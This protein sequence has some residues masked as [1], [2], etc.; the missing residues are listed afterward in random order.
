VF[1]FSGHL[2]SVTRAAANKLLI[3]KRARPYNILTGY[4]FFPVRRKLALARRLKGRALNFS[5]WLVWVNRVG[6]T[7]QSGFHNTR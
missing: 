2:I 4:N 1:S 7:A 5:V 6:W 3:F